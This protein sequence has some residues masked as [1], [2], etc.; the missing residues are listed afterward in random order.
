MMHR[1]TFLAPPPPPA[2]AEPVVRIPRSVLEQYVGVYEYLPGQMSRTDLRIVVRLE[3]D[4][5]MRDIGGPQILTPISETRFRV[6]GTSLLVEFV[7][8]E[9]GVTQVLG[10]GGQQMLARLTSKR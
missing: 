6:A 8:D 1:R 2:P 10:S 5:L 7:I 9:A 4:T 3:G